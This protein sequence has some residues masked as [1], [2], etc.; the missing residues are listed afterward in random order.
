MNQKNDFNEYGFEN[1]ENYGNNY[2]SNYIHS[3]LLI[4]KG[5]NQNGTLN[6]YHQ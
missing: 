1:N 4:N 3:N 2:S 6:N 5:D